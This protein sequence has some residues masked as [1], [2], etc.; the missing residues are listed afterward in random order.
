MDLHAVISSLLT[1]KIRPT[2]PHSRSGATKQ[3]ERHSRVG[4]VD[5]EEFLREVD[6]VRKLGAK[7]ITLKTGAYPMRELAMAIR[8]SSEIKIDLW[9]GVFGRPR[10]F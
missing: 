10:F 4:F 3:F 9:G 6:R 8:W 5:K 7:R 1:R 2:R